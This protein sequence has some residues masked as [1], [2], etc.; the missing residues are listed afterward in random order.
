MSHRP[1][2]SLEALLDSQ[3]DGERRAGLILV[4]NLGWKTA[5]EH[6]LKAVEFM[7]QS[8]A[9]AG[10]V[11]RAEALAV[12]QISKTVGS[13]QSLNI[14]NLSSPDK[15][16]AATE[17]RHS[18]IQGAINRI[19]ICGNHVGSENEKRVLEAIYETA[20]VLARYECTIVHGPR[21]AGIT[22]ANLCHNQF[23]AQMIQSELV[24]VD[25]SRIVGDV[26]LVIVMGGGPMTGVEIDIAIQHERIIAPIPGT[27]G[28]ADKLVTRIRTGKAGYYIHPRIL[29]LALIDDIDEQGMWL[30][31]TM[32]AGFYKR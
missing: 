24:F 16:L 26:Q 18:A 22:V 6:W 20:R 19:A 30:A 32:K 13:N 27:T 14:P 15:S 23:Q 10:D 25:R 1:I 9:A 4:S 8:R 21:G 28:E 7:L 12:E 2:R 29:Q 17:A 5:V 3:K 11:D 31:E